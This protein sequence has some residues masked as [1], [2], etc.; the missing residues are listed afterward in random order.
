MSF[1]YALTN[2]N[3]NATFVLN[4]LDSFSHNLA[5]LTVIVMDNASVHHAKMIQDRIPIWQERGLFICYLPPYSP[6][7]NII[8]RLWKEVKQAWLRPRDYI[9][10]DSLSYAANRVFANIGTSLSLNFS[11]FKV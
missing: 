8:E 10:F 4:Y 6:H 5:K 1:H 7:L 2:E 11:S 9:S 3:I